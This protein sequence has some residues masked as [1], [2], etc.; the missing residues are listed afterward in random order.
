M[1]SL[2]NGKIPL[3]KVVVANTTVSYLNASSTA[4][5]MSSLARSVTSTAGT[6]FAS[7]FS[8]RSST[9][10]FVLPYTEV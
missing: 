3:L 10:F 7:S 9:A 1:N 2:M 4:S 5:A 8:A 6:P